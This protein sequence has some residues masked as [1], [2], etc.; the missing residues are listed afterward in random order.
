MAIIDY[1]NL[2]EDQRRSMDILIRE[3]AY[4]PPPPPQPRSL[5]VPVRPQGVSI[6]S[7]WRTAMESEH[8]LPS[9]AQPRGPGVQAFQPQGGSIPLPRYSDYSHEDGLSSKY[10]RRT[11]LNPRPITSPKP[12]GV[13]WPQHLNRLPSLGHLSLELITRRI[14]N[15][16]DAF[17][18]QAR[19]AA[20]TRQSYGGQPPSVPKPM[21]SSRTQ[22]TAVPKPMPS[23]RTQATAVP[24]PVPSLSSV[25]P[26]YNPSQQA[27]N[28]AQTS[29]A[30]AAGMDDYFPG[31]KPP[32]K[33]PK[34]PDSIDWM[35]SGRGIAVQ[36]GLGYGLG[37]LMSGGFALSAGA[38]PSQALGI[39]GASVAGDAAG[40]FLGHLA[41]TAAI[42]LLGPVAP[43]AGRMIGGMIGGIAGDRLGWKATGAEA[44]LNRRYQEQQ[45]QQPMYD[46]QTGQQYMASPPLPTPQERMRNEILS[47]AHNPYM[48]YMM[49]QLGGYYA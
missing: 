46:P 36:E 37:G 18:W 44:D 35:N 20:Q 47:S 11:S 43:F 9:P 12:Y 48:P 42:P 38:T 28:A 34:P 25:V 1:W 31:L 40:S 16:Y 41:G 21:S 24:Q 17:Y 13:L 5:G 10:L 49:A 29:Q 30:Y 22:A 3:G 14:P 15:V 8:P 7:P 2:P 33:M 4:P 39:A 45:M 23:F 26:R 6:P 32:R 19:S 27:A